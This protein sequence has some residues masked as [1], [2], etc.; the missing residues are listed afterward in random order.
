[1]ATDKKS[2]ILYADLIYTIEKL[3]DET[4]GKLLKLI[5]QYVNDKDPK[6][7]DFVLDL[8]F[9]PIKQQLKRDLKDW[10]NERK[11]RSEAG[12]KGMKKRWKGAKDK[13][14]NNKNNS[15]KKT[16]TGDNSVRES[17][18]NIT[19]NV[20]VNETV[21]VTVNANDNVKRESSGTHAPAIIKK[22]ILPEINEV[23]SYIA[24]KKYTISATLFFDYYS[25]RG[26]KIDG[27]DIFNWQKLI[28]VWQEREQKG[29][30]PDRELNEQEKRNSG[31][32]R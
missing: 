13:K 7:N 29:V 9:E 27:Q 31:M 11:S 10:E 12:K 6:V 15:V 3:P 32:V 26:W 28:D 4:A 20:S 21:S 1:M 18:T 24:V 17:I 14:V 30:K 16:L 23:K 25:A 2:F 8:V 5:L 22:L 19:D